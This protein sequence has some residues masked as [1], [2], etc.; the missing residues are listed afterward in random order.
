MSLFSTKKRIAAVGLAAALVSTVAGIALAGGFTGSATTQVP[1]SSSSAWTVTLGAVSCPNGPL[2]PV[3]NPPACTVGYTVTNNSGDDLTLNSIYA[4]IG[5]IL[6]GGATQTV[7]TQKNGLQ[8]AGCD[9][10]VANPSGTDLNSNQAT[11]SATS[12]FTISN[13]LPTSITPHLTFGSSYPNGTSFTGGVA[14][15]VL[16]PEAAVQNACSGAMPDV[17]VTAA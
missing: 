1:V 13:S 4:T 12:W 11:G 14:T 9:E 15:I 16:N 7:I 2:N 6:P 3:A 5:T 17:T 10:A 8:V